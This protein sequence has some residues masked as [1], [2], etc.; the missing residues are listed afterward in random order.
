M[1]FRSRSRVNYIAYRIDQAFTSGGG[2]LLIQLDPTTLNTSTVPNGTALGVIP[3]GTDI[4]KLSDAS[5]SSQNLPAKVLC[6]DTA[7]TTQMQ[8][9]FGK[10][11]SSTTQD[12]ASKVY[13]FRPSLP[14]TYLTGSLTFWV[15]YTQLQG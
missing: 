3:A 9:F 6:T 5:T 15:N 2:N 11:I 7:L 1:L 12:K 4:G 8:P 10:W 14:A 13:L